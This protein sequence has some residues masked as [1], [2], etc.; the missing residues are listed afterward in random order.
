MRLLKL[1]KTHVWFFGPRP[2]GHEGGRDLSFWSFLV[3]MPQHFHKC[4][5]LVLY[6]DNLNIFF[7]YNNIKDG[8]LLVVGR[9][10]MGVRVDED[11]ACGAYQLIWQW[12]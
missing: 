8:R 7:P 9:R 11:R 6:E 3:Y 12:A 10:L 2:K 1:Q 5:K 4:L